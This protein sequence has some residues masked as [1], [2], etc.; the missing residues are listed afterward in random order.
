MSTLVVMLSHRIN[1]SVKVPLKKLVNNTITIA[2]HSTKS[3][4]GY[5][6]HKVHVM[7]V[8]SVETSE[9][10]NHT[11]YA[12][13]SMGIWENVRQRERHRTAH[14]G[15]RNNMHICKGNLLC[16]RQFDALDVCGSFIPGQAA[17]GRE[18]MM[19]SGPWIRHSSSSGW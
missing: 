4:H 7:C 3:L 9:E 16:E 19:Q 1:G 11:T 14:T 5:I 18:R 8:L 17:V 10:H 12:P 6:K 15:E 2:V 13:V